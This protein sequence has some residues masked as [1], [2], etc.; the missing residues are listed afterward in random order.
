MNLCIDP[1]SLLLIAIGLSMDVLSVAAVTGF[2]LGKMS[3]LQIT[4]LAISFGAFHVFMPMIGWLVGITIV[5]I[6]SGYDHWAAFILLLFVGG[7][8]LLEGFKNS[9]DSDPASILRINSLLI[10]SLAVSID[11]IAIGLTF[12][13]QK[14]SII[15]PALVI[16]LTAFIFTFL[17]VL[18]GSKVGSWMGRWAQI[19]GGIILI[20]IGIRVLLSHI[21]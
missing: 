9:K 3:S 14:V 16:G 4:R 1:S 6:I 17:G 12:S 21:L 11:S 19:I 10:F 7:R 2:C 8:M 15:I 13:L 20:G 5:D 18:A